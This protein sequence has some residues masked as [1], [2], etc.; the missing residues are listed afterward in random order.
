MSEAETLSPEA[1]RILSRADGATIAYHISAGRSPGV[2]FFGGFVSDMTGTK[3]MALEEFCRRRGQAYVRFDYFGHGASS[4]RFEDATIGRWAEDAITV[5]DAVTEGRQVLIGS[6][7]G[8][9]IMLLA[10]LA[11]PE[12]V[13]GLIG[14]AAAVDFTEDLLWAGFDDGMRRHLQRTGVYYQP[15]EYG[16]E[17]VPITW[18]LIEDARNDLLLR[19]PIDIGCPVRLIHGL[20]DAD[21]PWR[22]SLAVCEALTSDD[23]ELTL[24]K[25]GGHRLSEPADLE[26]LC[27]VMAE[28]CDRLE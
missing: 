6:S 20:E 14:I 3:A 7:M 26:R 16:E 27:R 25:G 15:S 22:T 2:M 11:R 10:A 21:V 23:V 12:R 4:G 5:L 28:L 17:P 19:E 1:P 9:W 24:V 18:R 8:A 13:A